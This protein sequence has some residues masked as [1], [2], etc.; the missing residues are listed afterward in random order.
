[1]IE[2]GFLVFELEFGKKLEEISCE[3]LPA[4][5]GPELAAVGHYR[6][7]SEREMEYEVIEVK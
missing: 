7:V 4:A 2:S 5:Q 1:M 6:V 3:A